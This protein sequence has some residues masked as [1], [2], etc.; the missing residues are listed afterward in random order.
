MKPSFRVLWLMAALAAPLV[1]AAPTAQ[2]PYLWLEGVTDSKAL[3]WVAQRNA[4]SAKAIASTPGFGDL[5]K[6]ILEILDSHAKIPTVKKIGP[7]Y[8][9]FWKDQQHERG[10]WRRTTLEEYRKPEPAWETVLDVDSLSKVESTNWVWHG[11]LA[12]TFL[13]SELK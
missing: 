13:W 4:D 11:A 1:A 8:Y 9:N 6:Q 2:D 10:L 5:E 12:Y 7:Y 3:D